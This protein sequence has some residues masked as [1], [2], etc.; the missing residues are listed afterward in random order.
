MPIIYQEFSNYQS[1][2]FLLLYTLKLRGV[3]FLHM[4]GRGT[5]Q[6]AHVRQRTQHML[7]DQVSQEAALSTPRG[8]KCR[9]GKA[10]RILHLGIRL[11][12]HR[13]ESNGADE[14]KVLM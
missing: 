5:M 9:G 10:L 13:V 8:S 11:R 2:C 7:K 4:E 6:K 12:F 3:F 14:V 1:R